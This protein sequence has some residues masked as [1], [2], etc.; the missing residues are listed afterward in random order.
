MMFSPLYD[1]KYCRAYFLLLRQN[2]TFYLEQFIIIL[3]NISVRYYEWY[4][5][6]L[7]PSIYPRLIRKSEKSRYAR[8]ILVFHQE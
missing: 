1:L 2:K 3:A 7:P 4:C 5:D 8:P 6:V